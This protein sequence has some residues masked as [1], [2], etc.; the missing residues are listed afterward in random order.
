[1]GFLSV[2]AAAAATFI[3][4]G[5]WYGALG[6]PW[7][8]AAGITSE[9]VEGGAMKSPGPFIISFIMLLVVAGMMRHGLAMAGIE[10]LGKSALAGFGIGAFMA[11]P[12]IVTNHAYGMKPR[13]LTLIDGGYA[14]IGCTVIGLVLGLF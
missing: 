11:T 14:T 12:W 2:L 10:S 4:G 13:M 7:M 8:K 9:Q 6:K 5:A 3:F 1:M